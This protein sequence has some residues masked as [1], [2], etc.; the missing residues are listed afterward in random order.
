MIVDWRAER[1]KVYGRRQGSAA[2]AQ[3]IAPVAVIRQVWPPAVPLIVSLGSELIIYRHVCQI[4]LRHRCPW[5]DRIA[6][7][8]LDVDVFEVRK[9]V[10]GDVEC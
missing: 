8:V 5:L 2:T 3:R 10:V 7:C 1:P 4:V 9:P 6:A